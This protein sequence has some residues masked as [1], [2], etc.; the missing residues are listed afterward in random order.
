M[1]VQ[2][3]GKLEG[4]VKPS[5]NDQMVSHFDPWRAHNLGTTTATISVPCPQLGG[6]NRRAQ[7]AIATLY[8]TATGAG[9]ICTILSG[10][11]TIAVYRLAD[12]RPL[13]MN[14]FPGNLTIE[15]TQDLT[16]TVSG[17]TG[18]ASVTAT[19]VIYR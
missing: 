11:D 13:Q 6:G 8:A 7:L 12:G 14:F 19:G 4:N 2:S 17:A 1:P 9:G 18:N 3:N 10:S 16:I 15:P 5:P